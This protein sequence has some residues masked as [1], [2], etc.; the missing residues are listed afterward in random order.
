[1][2]K[3]KDDKSYLKNAILDLERE[4]HERNAFK[5]SQAGNNNDMSNK[6][7]R[8]ISMASTFNPFILN[9]KDMSKPSFL[10]KDAGKQKQN[11]KFL[12]YKDRQQIRGSYMDSRDT[13]M[14]MEKSLKSNYGYLN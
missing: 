10:Q 7:Q 3:I 6:F 12:T 4:D 9:N 5:R 1:M 8:S 2:D 11:N 13:S 14:K